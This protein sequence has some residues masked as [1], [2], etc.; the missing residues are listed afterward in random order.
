MRDSQCAEEPDLP[1]TTWRRPGPRA[2][3]RSPAKLAKLKDPILRRLEHLAYD[4][5]GLPMAL[6][7]VWPTPGP[8]PARAPAQYA[9]W[10]YARLFWRQRNVEG[11]AN[12]TMPRLPRAPWAHGQAGRAVETRRGAPAPC[13]RRGQL[14]SGA[15]MAH[16]MPCGLRWAAADPKRWHGKMPPLSRFATGAGAVALVLAF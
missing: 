16:E 1:A 2:Q 15:M 11:R 7:G 6:H 9:H 5:T 10:A 14:G 12:G 4:A 3:W 8:S 13:S